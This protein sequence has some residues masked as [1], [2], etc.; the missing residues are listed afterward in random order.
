MSRIAIVKVASPH[1]LHWQPEPFTLACLRLVGA[2]RVAE[3]LASARDLPFMPQLTLPYLAA[4][5]E[6]YNRA[7]G[8]DHVFTVYDAPEAAL[9]RI[10]A[11]LVLLTA[12]TTTAPAVYRVSD[13]LR[14]RG[15]PTVIG[16]IHASTLPD[17]AAAHAT[18]VATGEGERT[19]AE[20]LADFDAG[21]PLRPRYVGGHG[22][23]LEHL[24]V[25]RWA[26][27]PCPWVVPVQTSRGC[28]NACHFCSTTRFQGVARRHRPV[29]EIVAEL[30]RLQDEGVI[31]P[32]KTVFFTDN[33]VVSDTDHTRGV[34]DTRYARELFEALVPLGISWVGQGEVEA[35]ADPAFVELMAASGCCLL[36][37]GLESVSQE[38]LDG[39]GKRANAVE[40]YADCLDT[41]HRHGIANI[42]CFIVGLDDDRT[43]VFA[44]TR[45]FIDRYVDVPQ[46]SIMTPF[47]GTALYRRLEREG[48]LLHRDWSRYDITHV[49]HRPLH[50]TPAEL[51]AGYAWLAEQLYTPW[52]LG[53]RALRHALRGSGGKARPSRLDRFSLVLAPNLIYARLA[54]IER[55]VGG[56]SGADLGP[57]HAP[58]SSFPADPPPAASER[59]PAA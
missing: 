30:R 2:R 40:R 1:D 21:R 47:P 51:E 48:R 49:V 42:G 18:A 45:A 17:E 5:G 7:T 4:L 39:V 11:D 59:R 23:A 14:A 28:R 44:R 52:A 12:S 19:L 41:L 9:G 56:A 58:L 3:R 57:V 6:A 43:D 34:R 55:G 50:M 54:R 37:I 36:L 8:R 24:E 32:S 27:Y 33:N 35:G 10:E 22:T 29:A 20:L 15:I 38:N 31:T 25:P 26:G 46:L 16:G 13:R 53:R